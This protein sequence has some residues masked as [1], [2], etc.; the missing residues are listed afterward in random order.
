M[1]CRIC[2]GSFNNPNQV[3]TKC[4]NPDCIEGRII[5]NIPC[6]ND[7]PAGGSCEDCQIIITGTWQLE[8]ENKVEWNYCEYCK[9][10]GEEESTCSANYHLKPADR[11]P[12]TCNECGG[13]W[14]SPQYCAERCS[15]ESISVKTC[16]PCN[17][18]GRSDRWN[19]SGGYWFSCGKCSGNGKVS[20]RDVDPNDCP[21]CRGSNG[22]I[23]KICYSAWHK[24]V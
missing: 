5:V 12:A 15:H 11:A 8:W 13:V 16:Q 14:D 19:E 17:G 18:T 4:S 20:T 1:P 2:K 22:F 24:Q 7:H 9:G 23:E 6:D 21:D 3:T 10:R